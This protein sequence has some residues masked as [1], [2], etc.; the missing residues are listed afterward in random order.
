MRFDSA[1]AAGLDEDKVALVEDGYES[2]LS[3]K[4]S[5]ALQLTDLIIGRPQAPAPELIERLKKHYSD[6]E[7]VE[8]SL[9]V[10]LFLGMSKVLI[11]LGLEPK[12]MPVTVVATP[13]SQ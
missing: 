13:G 8:I 7:L 11:T 5:L 6:A 10:G 9:A 2:D 1:R 3:E 4:E 12:D